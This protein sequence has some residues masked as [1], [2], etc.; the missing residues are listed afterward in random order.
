MTS[1]LALKGMPPLVFPSNT[2]TPVGWIDTHSLVSGGTN[3]LSLAGN[4]DQDVNKMGHWRGP[5]YLEYVND[6][7]AAFSKGM[8]LNMQQRVHVTNAA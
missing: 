1:L 7:I 4:K 3:T 6:E 2:G 8:F 5:H